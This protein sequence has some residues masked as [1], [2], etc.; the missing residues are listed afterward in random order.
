[1]KYVCSICGYVYDEAEN[2]PWTELPENWKCPLC[3]AAKA[4]FV[5]EGEPHSSAEANAI[6]LEETEMK[7]LTAPETSALCSNLARGCEKQYKPEQAAAFR[8]L[9]DWFASQ[10]QA[11][12]EPSFERLLER[13]N[14]DLNENYPAANAVSKQNG[15]RGALR[16][17]T[18]SEKVTRI[19]KSLLA[20]YAQ[21]GNAMLENTEVYVCTI[22]G[23]VYIGNDLPEVCPVCKVPNRKFEKIGG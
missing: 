12:P 6:H 23:F 22:C 2:T 13:V 10:S 5:P 1:M 11:D 7:P 3:G 8:K 4:D 17:L 14:S 15:D 16:S 19:L 18:W 21:E 9:A 20:R